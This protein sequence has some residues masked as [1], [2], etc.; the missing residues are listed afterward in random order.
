MQTNHV[1]IADNATK[2]KTATDG[3]GSVAVKRTGGE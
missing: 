3:D 1:L 2:I